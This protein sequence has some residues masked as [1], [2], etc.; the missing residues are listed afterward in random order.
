MPLKNIALGKGPTLPIEIGDN[1]H[2]GHPI[3]LSKELD[4]HHDIFFAAVELTR[5]PM[6]LTDP[7]Q[8]DNPIIFANIAF[9]EM[10]GYDKDEVIGHNCR[11]LQGDSTNREVVDDVREAIA[12]KTDI[13]TEILNYRK[14]G[15]AFWNALFISPVFSSTGDLLY[16]FASQLDVSR[17]R[18]AEDA[19]RQAQKME[20]VGQLTGGI[21]HDFNNL[22]TV[23]MGNIDAASRAS[24]DE[25]RAKLLDR[26]MQGAKKAEQLTSQLLA[27]ARK[28]RLE[29]RPTSLNTLASN[30]KDLLGRTLGTHFTIKLELDND[31]WIAH[32]DTVQAETALL[33]LIVNARDAMPDGGEVK[34]RTSH[35][36]LTNSDPLV[37]QGAL[38]AGS[39]AVLSVMDNG[40]GIPADILSRVTEPFFTT[41]DVGRGTGMGLSMVYGFMRQSKGRLEIESKPGEGTC[42]SLWF[43]ATDEQVERTAQEPQRSQKGGWETI[44]IVE[45]NDDVL[46]LAE[47]VL[48]DV[49]Y[50]VITASNGSDAM[51]ILETRG[52]EIDM[53]FTDIIMPGGVNGISVAKFSQTLN[54]KPKVLVTTGWS[55]HNGQEPGGDGERMGFPVL[56]KPYMP[57]A[58]I[59]KIRE[60]MDGHVHE[61]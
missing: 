46:E 8:F 56:S 22:L 53:V 36:K 5:M 27:F 34:L 52:D 24:D 20:A 25:R 9:L 59:R 14:D 31:P 39:Y 4:G 61:G 48:S 19:L 45:D 58:L 28:Q 1:T 44:L 33:N 54:K 7:N 60:T 42:I 32:V 30:M 10:T 37:L 11:F 17:R 35:Q 41:K 29:T 23:V 40:H 2:R 16:F 21:A 6:I 15:S 38:A 50:T 18:D 26:A 13:A 57:T 51:S 55:S 3:V 12:H 43:P 49:G 47:S